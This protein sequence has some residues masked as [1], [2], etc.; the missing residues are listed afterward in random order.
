MLCPADQTETAKWL[1]EHGA[2]TQAVDNDG[3]S[4]LHL[5]VSCND[6]ELV[7]WLCR[8]CGV[9]VNPLDIDG[10]TPL[11]VGCLNGYFEIVELLDQTGADQTIVD[12]EGDTPLDDA[13]INQ[14]QDI[15]DFY[16]FT[17]LERAQPR[18]NPPT[19]PTLPPACEKEIMSG[20]MVRWAPAHE[21]STPQP[22]N[23]TYLAENLGPFQFME[24]GLPEGLSMNTDSGV[25]SGVVDDSMEGERFH[26]E[27][28]VAHAVGKN[29][30]VTGLLSLSLPLL[31]Y[32][33]GFYLCYT[34]RP[35]DPLVFELIV[36]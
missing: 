7:Y 16:F 13:K 21:M 2:D 20:Q 4:P 34:G 25:I 5:A 29:S 27:I 9:P 33:V 23:P 10:R 14:H 36:T 12:A 17:T 30:W 35:S 31:F 24:R 8:E 6:Y 15:L 18:P 11:H 26:V 3:W 22:P 1:V 19:Y 28:T 32:Y